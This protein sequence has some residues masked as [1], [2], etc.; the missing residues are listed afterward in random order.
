MLISRYMFNEI[1]L[2]CNPLMVKFQIA[3]QHIIGK[4]LI[5][6]CPRQLHDSMPEQ[7]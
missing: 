2:I 1:V 5:R 3:V 7:W 6:S 4:K